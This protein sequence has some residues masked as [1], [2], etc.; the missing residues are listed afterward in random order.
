MTEKEFIRKN[1]GVWRDLENEISFFSARKGSRKADK[2][3]PLSRERID[4][5]IVLYNQAAN[6]LAYCRTFF[7]KTETEYYLNRLVGKAHSIL[8]GK[9][10]VSLRDGVRYLFS[11]FQK[12]FRKEFLFFLL[13]FLLMVI[14]ALVGFLYARADVRNAEVFLGPVSLREEGNY[15]DFV[16]S[17]SAATGAYIGENNILVCREALAGGFTLGIFTVYLLIYNGWMVGVLGGYEAARGQGTFFWSLILPHG[18]TELF[19]IMLSGMAGFLIA[20]AIIHPG[21]LRRRTN[22]LLAGKK[23]IGII[24]V[25]AIWLII[26]AGIEAWFTPLALP[27]WTKY[28]F[29]AGMFVLLLVYLLLPGARKKNGRRTGELR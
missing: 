11:G 16:A 4:R 6:H 29:A 17:V 10:A 14:P 9:K 28:A 27:Y 13:A 22:L 1:G 7:G 25:C 26:S 15:D 2:D 3:G 19:A 12:T 24:C 21:Q 23:A 5:F 18:V 20:W 8:Y